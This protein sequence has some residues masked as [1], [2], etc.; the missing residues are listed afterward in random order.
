MLRTRSPLSTTLYHRSNQRR[1][2]FDLHVLSTP[3]AFI[4]SQDQTLRIFAVIPPAHLLLPARS[5]TTA[6]LR[7]AHSNSKSSRSRN[8]QLTARS[9][10]CAKLPKTTDR[11]AGLAYLATLQL[12]MCRELHYSTTSRPRLT[13]PDPAD[14]HQHVLCTAHVTDSQTLCQQS[15]GRTPHDFRDKEY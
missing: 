15:C 8:A 2:P 10:Q 14:L 6:P 11:S 1:F 9:T 13:N 3:P 4:L 12:L 5:R 7:K